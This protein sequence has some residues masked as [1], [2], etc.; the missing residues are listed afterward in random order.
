MSVDMRLKIVSEKLLGV[1]L[2][3]KLN[4]DDQ[5]YDVCKKARGKLN[6]LARIPPLIRLSKTLA[7]CS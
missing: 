6:A 1:K 2:G 3:W 7:L 5:I 4:F